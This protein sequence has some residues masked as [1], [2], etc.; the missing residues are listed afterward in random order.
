[1]RCNTRSLLTAA[2]G[3]GLAMAGASA[4]A[5]TIYQDDFSGNGLSSLNG[6]APDVAPGA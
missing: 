5:I 3:A 6:A 1:M 2:L 4:S